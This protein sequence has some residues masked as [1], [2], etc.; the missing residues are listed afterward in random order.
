M[1]NKPNNPSLW[2]KAKSLARQKFDVYP[3]AYANGWAAKWY[4]GKGGTW[5][6]AEYGMQ[7]PYME[8]GGKPEWLLE[9][10]LKAQ[11]YSGNALSQK[12]AMMAEG[13]EPQN[14]GFQ[15]LPEYVQAKIL[16]NMGY[17]GYIPEM[18]Y[19]GAAQQDAIDRLQKREDRLV[20]KGYKAVDEGRENK[21]ER[22]LARA[23][24]V[25][26][27]KIRLMDSMA[28]GGM[29]YPFMQQGGEPDGEMALGQIAA[30][31]DKMDKLRQFIQPGSDL[32]P[33]ISSK[34]AVM[35]HYADAVSDYMMYNPEAQEMMGSDEMPEMGRGGY[36][37]TRSSDRKGKT[38]KVT[39]PDGT[40]KYFGDSKLGQHPKDPERKKAFYARHK[41]NLAG[42]PYFRAFAR[43]TWEDGGQIEEMANGGYVGYDGKRHKSNTPTWSGNVGYQD[44]GETKPIIT[45]NP[46]DP[47]LRA[48]RDSLIKYN[49][50]KDIKKFIDSY[51]NM[52]GKDPYKMNDYL[53]Y[54]QM[55]NASNG[56]NI[57]IG[58]ENFWGS[59]G[60]GSP[61]ISG[62][63][64][65]YKKPVQP[66]IYK[67]SYEDG[68]ELP[69]AQV[70][71]FTPALFNNLSQFVSSQQGKKP[72][73]PP[74][75][76]YNPNQ[77]AYNMSMI[78]SGMMSIGEPQGAQLTGATSANPY[79][80]QSFS[81][82]AAPVNPNQTQ[83]VKQQQPVNPIFGDVTKLQGTLKDGSMKDIRKG[84]KQFNQTYG[85]NLKV[86]FGAFGSKGRENMEKFGNASQTAQ[87]AIGVGS[88]ATDLFINNPRIKKENQQRQVMSGMTDALN[89]AAP[90]DRGDWV[91]AGSRIGE[92]RPDQYVVNK[93]MYTGQFYPTMNMMQSGG[94]IDGEI[95]MPLSEMMAMPSSTRIPEPG[96]Y[97]S[98]RMPIGNPSLN[99]TLDADFEDYATKAEKYIR[100]VNP[101]TDITGEMLALGA[102]EAYKKYGKL[103]PVEL[104]LAQ[105]QQEGYLAKGSKPNKPQRTRN[106]FNVGNTDD[107]SVVAYDNL[108]RGVNTYFDLV[109]SQ[110]LQKRTPQQLLEN[111]VNKAGNRYA[112]DRRYED[113]LKRIISQ[114]QNRSFEEGGVYD[115]SE[116]EIRSILSAGGNVE[117]L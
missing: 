54:L 35:D 45:S 51:H 10:Q 100:S 90:E 23:A 64:N 101:K 1:A 2:S 17:G 72:K 31:V 61:I 115:L 97:S 92:L 15:A 26:D 70:G 58:T 5:R 43:A 85:S 108:Q 82:T 29:T 66:V 94:V 49:S 44:G 111:Y 28:Y 86:P 48:Y 16:S 74:A 3:S 4:K 24:R 14:E 105:L 87:M 52:W 19:G 18:G 7:V 30:V 59:W 42:N 20:A 65:V 107:G 50:G 114:M 8:D 60:G 62:K 55:I 77:Q 91:A 56:S 96:A 21:A 84:V 36:V 38:H 12:M 32:E 83:Q 99:L 73:L 27:R 22:I 13:G 25:E 75:I 110:Y 57:P 106:P 69:M 112:S 79:M 116:D 93:G 71:L 34:L 76:N 102:Q 63:Y 117:F 39:G 103:V 88:L 6:K 46:K 67:K 89:M 104:A 109:A 47:M 33:W 95:D 68:G 80:W 78:G 41:K 81:Q 11:G 113:S 37:V 9:A 53:D 98:D 40:V